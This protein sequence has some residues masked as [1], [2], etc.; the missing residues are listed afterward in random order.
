MGVVFRSGVRLI[1]AFVWVR[2]YCIRISLHP[3][4]YEWVDIGML[5]YDPSKQLYLVKRIHVPHHI[6]QAQRS[7][8][9]SDSFNKNKISNNELSGKKSDTSSG[10]ESDGVDDSH[11]PGDDVPGDAS[12]PSD[13][14]PGE[15]GGA[16]DGEQTAAQSKITK[17][18]VIYVKVECYLYIRCSCT[19]IWEV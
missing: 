17:P 15:A 18:Q 3:C 11:K 14:V 5:D 1:D 16:S 8:G 13:G 10:S 2:F 4:R 9:G 12:V 7:K 6:L 19:V